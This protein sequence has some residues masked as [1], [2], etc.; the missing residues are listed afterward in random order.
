M[1]W[2]WCEKEFAKQGCTSGSS[3]QASGGREE[4]R[5]GGLLFY[6]LMN[7]SPFGQTARRLLELN[8]RLTSASF[9]CL[10]DSDINKHHHL[11]VKTDN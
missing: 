2:K 4:G 8:L 3:V 1:G 5:E 11:T 9:Q 10:S 7:I 6:Y